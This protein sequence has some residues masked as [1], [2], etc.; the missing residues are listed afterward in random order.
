MV[1]RMDTTDGRREFNLRAFTGMCN[2]LKALVTARAVAEASGRS[3]RMFWQLYP[4]CMCAFDQLFQ[5][6]WNITA[7]PDHSKIE[8]TDLTMTGQGSFPDLL[9]SSEPVLSMVCNSE[10]IAPR[11]YPHH[12]PLD[13][14][15]QALLEELEPVPAIA[16]RVNEFQAKRFR[17][18]MIGVHLRRGDFIAFR[19]DSVA[20]EDPAIVVVDKWLK[21]APDAGIL[22]CTDDGAPIPRTDTRAPYQGLRERFQ[23]RYGERVVWTTPRSLDRS[24]P[25]AIQ[26]GL[27]DF[28]LLRRT[29]YFVG[30]FG[31]SFS[32]LA[33][34][35][36]KVPI[37]MA[38][39]QTQGS[40]RMLHLLYKTRLIYL[41]EPL[42]RHEFG[43]MVHPSLLWTRYRRRFLN[44]KSQF[45]K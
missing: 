41:L 18:Q 2:R 43:G 4:S 27:V 7:N 20:N 14:R 13:L 39:G 23:F 45:I 5:N 35:G 8:W 16:E 36:R 3:F 22:L 12:K 34:Y 25:E 9:A 44:F 21:Q 10:L 24:T 37:E 1:R 28:L 19:P 30:T 11:R 15:A 17:S 29:N 33:A 32:R 38:T 40:E 42:I 26:D 6:D 31:S